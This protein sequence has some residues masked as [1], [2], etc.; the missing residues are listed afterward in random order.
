MD[1]EEILAK[2]KGIKA[3]IYMASNTTERIEDQ[4]YALLLMSENL[5]EIIDELENISVKNRVTK[6]I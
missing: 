2:L 3:Q 4:Q 6:D 1:I 5:A